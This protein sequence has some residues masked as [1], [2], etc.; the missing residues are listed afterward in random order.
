MLT[1]ADQTD[2][3][4]A[5]TA[6]VDAAIAASPGLRLWGWSARESAGSAAVATFKLVH[7]A[8]VSGGVAFEVVELAADSSARQQY[9]LGIHC[10][11]GISID[12]VAGTVDVHLQY[13]A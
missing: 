12:H 8:T 7:G 13:S 2:V 3:S 4:A 9:P 1:G 6:D 11:N 5:V 10:P